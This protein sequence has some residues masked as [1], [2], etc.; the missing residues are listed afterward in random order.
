MSA[1]LLHVIVGVVL[2]VDV[3]PVTWTQVENSEVLPLG[4]VA[5]AVMNWP[6]ATATGRVTLNGSAV[7]LKTSQVP[8]VVTVV[9]PIK[10]CP[11]PWPEP[12]HAALAKSS[13]RY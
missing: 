10:V 7:G 9:E 4:S 6:T 11:S 13:I 2:G 3:S 5:V 12:S 1:G 8:S